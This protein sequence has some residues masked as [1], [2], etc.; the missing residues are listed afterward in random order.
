[1]VVSEE[2]DASGTAN[3][4]GSVYGRYGV[5]SL[6]TATKTRSGDSRISTRGKPK[7]RILLK[8]RSEWGEG[9]ARSSS[10]NGRKIQTWQEA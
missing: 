6:C 9:V 2:H 3:V 5:P 10:E 7:S 8:Y 4:P 1:M